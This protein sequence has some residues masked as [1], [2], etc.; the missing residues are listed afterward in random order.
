MKAQYLVEI[1]PG[2]R[3]ECEAGDRMELNPQDP[4]IVKFE[5]YEDWGRILR[6]L[7]EVDGSSSSGGSANRSDRKGA[8]HSAQGSATPVIVRTMSESD[9]ERTGEIGERA[10][11]M[12]KTAQRKVR[13][14]HLAM[15]MIHCHYSFDKRLALFQ[16][17]APGRVDFRSLVRDLSGALHT[18]VE[19]R[20]VGP[21]D[22]A[23]ML[24]GIGPCGRVFCC[25][26]VLDH[27]QSINV[28][29][30]KVQRLSLNPAS[31]SGGCGRLK[32]CLRYEV[33][34]YRE[35]GRNLP[36][37]GAQC[38]TPEGQGRALD[39]NPLTQRVRV[40]LEEDGQVKDFGAEEVTVLPRNPQQRSSGGK[41]SGRAEN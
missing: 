31:V 12:L 13:E 22:E 40:R 14:H 18:R 11:S 27:F 28:K 39:C 41:G 34:G 35:M 26:S 25:A 30:A 33:D 1:A 32:C 9:L 6:S 38:E 8:R 2:L 16:F 7:D 24:G 36:R 23:S 17:T 4:V 20:Q 5:R 10:V 29:M 3:F 21:R 15:K 19:F 37:S